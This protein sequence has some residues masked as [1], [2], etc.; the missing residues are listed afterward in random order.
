MDFSF[1]LLTNPDTLHMLMWGVSVTLRLFAGALVCGLTI[2]LLLSGLYLVPSKLLRWIIALYV[3]YHRNVPTVVQ[4]MV[5]YFGMP[6]VLPKA[7]RLWINQGNTE[8]S[9]ALIALS[10][11]VS[12]YY[13]EDIRSGIKAIAATQIEAARSIGLGAMQSLRY[14]ILPQ[15]MRISIPPI[16]NRSLI[17]FKDTSLAMVIGVTE[18]TYQVKKIEN[19]TFQTFQIFMISTLI[20]LVISLLIATLGAQVSRKFPANFKS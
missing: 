17:V 11:N 7:I 4:I 12:A 18:L 2:A 10:L 6:E 13:Y 19:T 20:Y 15:A 14:V 3:E 5:W 9:F 1:S 8:F 16:I